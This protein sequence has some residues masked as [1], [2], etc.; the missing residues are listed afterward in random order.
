MNNWKK[1]LAGFLSLTLLT[2][3]P[4]KPVPTP[5]PTPAPTAETTP[6]P[7]AT[8]TPTPTP[9]PEA[10]PT[11]TPTPTAEAALDEKGIYDTKDE[12]ALYLYT[13]HHLPDNFMTKKEARKQGWTGGALNRTIKGKCIGGDRFGNNEGHLPKKHTYYE[14]DIGTIKAK[15]RGE[16]RIVWSDD[17]DI[18]YTGDH[19]NTFELL[20]GDGK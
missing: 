12:V 1:L 6:T 16:K 13:Y 7:E 18:W 8:P 10:T 17:W 19:Y 14:C 3:C 20:Y 2:G 11:P 5:S 9:T 15:S 4:K